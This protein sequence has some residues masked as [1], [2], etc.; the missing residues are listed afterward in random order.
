MWSCVHP[1]PRP[2]ER[3]GHLSARTLR[4]FLCSP[5]LAK[6]KGHSSWPGL[7]RIPGRLFTHMVDAIFLSSGVSNMPE[8]Q[9]RDIGKMSD[10]EITEVVEAMQEFTSMHAWS[11]LKGITGL[12]IERGWVEEQLSNR[13]PPK[14]IAPDAEIIAIDECL[15]LYRPR[16]KRIVIFHRGVAAA[17]QI[18]KC[19][20]EDLQHVVTYHEWGHAMLH[21]GEDLDGRECDLRNYSR[22]DARVHESFAQLL[23]WRA[24][25]QNLR[26]SRN[27][28][29]QRRWQKIRDIFTALEARQPPAY[30]GW[31]RLEGVPLPKLEKILILI[32]RGTRFREWEGLSAVADS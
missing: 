21:V 25:E 28:R 18:L 12:G 16:E 11:V 30:R 17:A 24:I 14:E 32:R 20:A 13:K 6:S 4:V 3:E 29:V 26:N 1:S 27:P 8:G 19:E 10:E 7:R 23:A 15:G 22:I 2:A 31:R 5:L 9:S